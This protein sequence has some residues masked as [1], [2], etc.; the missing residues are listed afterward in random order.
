MI[1]R[2]VWLSDW[3]CTGFLL[4]DLH[5]DP[6]LK[7]LSESDELLGFLLAGGGLFLVEDDGLLEVLFGL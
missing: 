5:E 3:R 7:G 1:V 6:A 4:L 2:A